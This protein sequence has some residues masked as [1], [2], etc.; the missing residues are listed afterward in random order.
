MALSSSSYV[1]KNNQISQLILKNNYS[2]VGTSLFKQIIFHFS[3][4]YFLFFHFLHSIK[5]GILVMKSGIFSLLIASTMAIVISY[6]GV[7]AIN[8]RTNEITAE[9]NEMSGSGSQD[10]STVAVPKTF[11]ANFTVTD[12]QK[13]MQSNGYYPSCQC[14]IQDFDMSVSFYGCFDC[15]NGIAVVNDTTI[16]TVYCGNFESDRPNQE[17]SANSMYSVIMGNLLATLGVVF[18]A[19]MTS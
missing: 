3:I 5:I 10:N 1:H 16:G 17:N 18:F 4:S 11:C 12:S 6:E 9:M 8:N 7:T 13:I 14:S 2:T 15:V 19:T